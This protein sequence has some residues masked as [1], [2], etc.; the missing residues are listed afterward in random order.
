MLPR[1]VTVG[2][3]LLA[4][5]A[6]LPPARSRD[7]ALARDL[8]ATMPDGTVLLADRYWA[9]ADPSGPIVL[10]R[11]PYGRRRLFGTVARLFAERGYQVVIQSCRGTFGSGG[12][13]EAFQHEASDGRATLAWLEGQRWFSGSVGMFGASYAGST[14]WALASAAPSSLQALAPALSASDAR[15][16]IYPGGAFALETHLTWVDIV[17]SQEAPLWRALFRQITRPRRLA[18]AFRHLPLSETDSIVTRKRSQSFQD[19]LRHESLDDPWWQRARWGDD[20]AAIEAPVLLVA[21]WHDLF[22]PAQIEDYQRLRDAGRTVRLVVGPWTHLALGGFGASLRE[23]LAWFDVHLRGQRAVPQLPVRVF[24]TGSGWIELGDWPP[25]HRLTRWH[26]QA[27]G[28]LST[29]TPAPSAPDRYRYDPADPTPSIGGATLGPGAG[30]RDD[31]QLE[32]R[33]DVLTYSSRQLDADVDVI[34]PVTA[35]L[36]VRSVSESA[37]IFVRL[38]DVAPSG[39]STSVCDGLVSVAREPR[40]RAADGTTRVIVELWPT[41]YRLKR[42]HRLRV[43]VT[44][45]AHPRYARD[46][47]NGE[48]IASA[49][50]MRAV[51]QEVLHD[52]EHPSALILPVA[53]P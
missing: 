46:L 6:D 25:P 14:Q 10:I 28:G 23:A 11:S 37:Q 42:G 53:S 8:P 1:S 18:R 13:F 19:W 12:A 22:A 26:L 38:C 51:E 44:G 34:G 35:E 21:G 7:I 45:G 41:A 24:L 20:P 30:P 47:G 39:R 9:R 36:H 3:R 15:P 33:A 32:R 50:R 2:S 31:R 4:R 48:P 29:S 5:I 27:G 16:L 52:P 17:A 43:H 49:T 40:A